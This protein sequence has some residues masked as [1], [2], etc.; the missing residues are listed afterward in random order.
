MPDHD[1][2]VFVDKTFFGK[3]YPLV[4]RVID[5]AIAVAGYKHRKF[6]HTPVEAINIAKFLHSNDSDAISA[7][8]LHLIIDDMCSSD[9]KFENF[10]KIMAEKDKE[11]EK[12]KNELTNF[13]IEM[14]NQMCQNNRLFAEFITMTSRR[15]AE[16]NKK[17]WSLLSQ[18]VQQ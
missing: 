10:L 4:Q 18:S 17:L 1:I 5:S 8:I 13:V 3:S 2:H 6:F 11:T 16:D 14:M 7:A 15:L 9:K 12:N